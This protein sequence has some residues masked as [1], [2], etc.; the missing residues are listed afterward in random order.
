MAFDQQDD[1]YVMIR[2]CTY[3]NMIHITEPL[4]VR[5]APNYSILAAKLLLL[6]DSLDPS[7]MV[8]GQYLWDM[9]AH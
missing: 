8:G 6:I 9:R 3:M 2:R 7:F 4:S 5:L 1:I